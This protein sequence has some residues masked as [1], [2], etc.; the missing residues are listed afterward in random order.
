MPIRSSHI[1]LVTGVF[2]VLHEEHVLFLRKAKALGDRLVV[3]IES[4]ARVRRLKGSARPVVPQD[5][6]KIQLEQL[7]IA[8]EV[9]ILPEAFDTPD[10]HRQLLHK[11][12]PSILAV[13]SHTPHI[14]EKLQLMQEIGGRVEIVHQH[15]PAISSTIVINRSQP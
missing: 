4:D 15:N 8:D 9:F 5:Q 10:D 1:T 13:S 7:Q 3:G 12:R 6:R 2:D 11:I 14:A